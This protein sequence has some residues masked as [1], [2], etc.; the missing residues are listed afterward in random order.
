M[1]SPSRALPALLAAAS[2]IW[3]TPA[4]KMT[5]A[6]HGE[7]TCLNWAQTYASGLVMCGQGMEVGTSMSMGAPWGWAVL[8]D[9]GC[10]LL[11]PKLQANL[12]MKA[13]QGAHL[14]G[15]SA[16]SDAYDFTWCYVSSACKH[17]GGGASVN[18]QVSWKKCVVDEDRRYG[19]LHPS[20]LMKH[21]VAAGMSADPT[22]MT[23]MSYPYIYSTWDQVRPF[24]G[25][26]PLAKSSLEPQ[27]S[28]DLEAI[29]E[30]GRPMMICSN[31]DGPGN[32]NPDACGPPNNVYLVVGKELWYFPHLKAPTCIQ[33]C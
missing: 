9:H 21:V 7:C 22:L 18:D 25:N 11:Y 10:N 15:K 24:F 6:P 23:V 4:L 13:K 3:Q 16:E 28:K 31:L 29:V 26:D 20:E 32:G 17:L 2:C 30:S 5:A 12:C 1:A 33:G 14:Y 27:L 8:T 19:D